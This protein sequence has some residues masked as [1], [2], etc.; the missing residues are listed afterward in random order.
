MAQLARISKRSS[1]MMN[2]L[3]L[4]SSTSVGPKS[5]KVEED[6][7]VILSNKTH[8]GKEMEIP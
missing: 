2:F 6:P 1:M 4:N 8:K 5:D 3:R 7:N